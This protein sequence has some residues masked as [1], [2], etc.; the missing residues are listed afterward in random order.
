MI[1]C[2]HGSEGPRLFSEVKIKNSH[3]QRAQ[4]VKRVVEVDSIVERFWLSAVVGVYVCAR[5]AVA[6]T[7]TSRQKRSNAR[8]AD[9]QRSNLVR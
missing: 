2:N 4:L 3:R 8:A 6:K 5:A 7:H 9:G 1:P